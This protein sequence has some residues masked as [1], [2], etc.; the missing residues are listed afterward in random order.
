VENG[1]A[2]P[3]N[4]QSSGLGLNFPVSIVQMEMDLSTLSRERS[5]LSDNVPFRFM[6]KN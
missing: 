4:L 3:N 6:N 1:C 5:C 2:K